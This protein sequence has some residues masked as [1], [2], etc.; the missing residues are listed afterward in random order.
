MLDLDAE[1]GR[2]YFHAM[3]T[4]DVDAR[5]VPGDH[6]RAGDAV[7]ERMRAGALGEDGNVGVVAVERLHLAP[8]VSEHNPARV[9]QSAVDALQ[10]GRIELLGPQRVLRIG[11]DDDAI[12]RLRGELFAFVTAARGD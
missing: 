3:L 12:A 8:I 10:V 11:F 9:Q 7:E 5:L 2:L 4:P 6:G 1:A